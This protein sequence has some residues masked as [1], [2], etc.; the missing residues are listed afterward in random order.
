M[1]R[2]LALAPVLLVLA[3]GA[4]WA[5]EET[6]LALTIGDDAPPLDIEYWIKG[7]EM[8]RR[9]NFEPV[10]TIP[11]GQITVVEFWATWCGPCRIGMPHV[12]ELQEQYADQ[13]VRIIGV[14]DESLPKVYEFLWKIDPDGTIQNERTRYT[15]TTDPD[16]STHRDY[17]EAAGQRGIPT[18]FV[19]G[20]TGKIEW[21]GHPIRMDGVLEALV[22]DAW[23][24]EAFKQEFERRMAVERAM[25]AARAEIQKAVQAEDWEGL[26][27]IF[28]GL[29]EIDPDNTRMRM[30][31]LGIL[32]TR[33][34]DKERTYTYAEEVAKAVWDDAPSLNQI[35][36]Q[37]LDDAK[38]KHRDHDFAM[39]L[40]VRATEVS[41]RKDG[42]ILDTLARA[43]YEQGDLLKAVDIQKEAVAVAEGRLKEGVQKTLEAY[44]KELLERPETPAEEGGDAEE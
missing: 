35:A 26:I 24:R 4:A 16:R 12:S 28:E 9:G 32:L 5:D 8:D 37:I 34:D 39:K 6:P 18:A 38:V 44:E 40:A 27:A 36:W 7:V 42:A 41:E 29:I 20:R 30:Q 25:L 11:K 22:N 14:S 15:L 2:L 19:V 43:H 21:I 33:I 17:M 3:A 1:S 31:K 23:D 13:G 10:T